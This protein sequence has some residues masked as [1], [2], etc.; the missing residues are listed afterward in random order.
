[1]AHDVYISYF[2]EDKPAADAACAALEARGIPCWIAPRD[3]VPGRYLDE[4]IMDAIA[5]CRIMVVILSS[6][7]TGSTLV[8]REVEHAVSKGKP[9]IPLRVEDA[10]PSKSM[11]GLFD[12]R[13]E[14]VSPSKPMEPKEDILGTPRGYGA[15]MPPPETHLD[16]LAETLR[17]LLLRMSGDETASAPAHPIKP[18]ALN[19]LLRSVPAKTTP[20]G[21]FGREDGPRRDKVDCTVFAPPAARAGDAALVQVFAHRHREAR[22][23]KAAAKEFD[24]DAKRRGVKSLGTRIR[25]GSKLTFELSIPP[26]V[27]DKSVRELVWRGDLDSVEFAVGVPEGLSPRTVIGEVGIS[28]DS[29]PIGE[30]HFKLKVAAKDAAVAGEPVPA[31]EA[32]RYTRAFI[33]YASKDRPEV[34]CRVPMLSAVGIRFFTDVLSL[35]PGDEWLPKIYEWIDESNVF[36]LFWSSNAKRSEWVEKEWRHALARSAK[37]FIRPVV[38][39]GPPTPEPPP[40]LAH[41]SFGGRERYFL[42]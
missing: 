13:V 33:S 40:E 34:L 41:I 1:M 27:V 36:L 23:A 31:E 10:S 24:A 21:V 20:R 35:E 16:R 42:V 5:E 9:I 18:G 19:V 39:E 22:K 29:V 30:I 15:F 6:N 38:I 11:G 7:S 4:A 8:R 25:R 37:G 28:Q 12:L 32:V 26:L 3:I 14:D 17:L 2:Y